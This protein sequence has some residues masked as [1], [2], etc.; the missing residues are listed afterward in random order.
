LEVIREQ[1]A[2]H[3]AGIAMLHLLLVNKSLAFEDLMKASNLLGVLT[4]ELERWKALDELVRGSGR[5]E[6]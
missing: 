4:H 2:Q 5:S 6:E 1:I 3:E